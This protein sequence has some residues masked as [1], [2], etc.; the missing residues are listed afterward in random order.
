MQSLVNPW[1][2]VV[3][4]GAHFLAFA[5]V[6]WKKKTPRYVPALLTFA[7]LITVFAMIATDT[8]FAV[9]EYS[10]RVVLR[11][12]AAIS[13]VCSVSYLIYRKVNERRTAAARS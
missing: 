9:G 10:G 12:T 3:L 2:M 4:F 11:V 5:V 8:D 7:L 6:G 13:A 1:A